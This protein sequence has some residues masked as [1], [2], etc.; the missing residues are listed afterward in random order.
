MHEQERATR[1]KNELIAASFSAWQIIVSNGG[2]IDW[3]KHLCSLGL[4]DRKHELS[5]N[6]KKYLSEKALTIAEKIQRASRGK[7]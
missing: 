2:K 7:R 1:Q 4:S 6:M 3:E 5:E